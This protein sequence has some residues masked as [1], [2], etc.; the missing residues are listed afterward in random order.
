MDYVA[1]KSEL[2]NDPAALGYAP[3][4]ASGNDGA[5][6]AILND[7]ALG[8]SKG[9]KLDVASV[10]AATLQCGV[11]ASE[12]VALTQPMR[13]LWQAII[14]ASIGGVPVKNQQLRLQIG[15]VWAA[16]TNSRA[17]MLAMQTR[18]CTRAELLFGEGVQVTPA[19][20]AIALRNT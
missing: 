7:L 6:A 4:I 14:S 18:S 9:Y 11:Q 8:T 10:D 17:N 3:H 16:N 2:V 5:L 12:Y 19:D 20:I 13:E 15:A 1:L